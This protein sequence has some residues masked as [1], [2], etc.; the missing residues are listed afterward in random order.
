MPERIQQILNR[1]VEWWKNFSTRQKAL[2]I[3]IAAVVAVAFSILGFVMTRPTMVNLITCDSAK[4]A[5][6]V[7]DL[8][9]SNSIT[10]E[11]SDD[12]LTYTVKQED[13]RRGRL[14]TLVILV[15][16]GDHPLAVYDTEFLKLIRNQVGVHEIE[17]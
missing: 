5:S 2:I 12:G 15:A 7:K 17:Q 13:R 11:V 8:L 14:R 16:H 4:Q 1:I 10:Y 9:D 6:S 3:S